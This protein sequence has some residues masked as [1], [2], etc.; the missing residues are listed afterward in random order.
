[1]LNMVGNL[2]GVV[3]IPI[4]AWL[5]GRGEWTGAFALGTALIFIGAALWLLIDAERN[6][7]ESATPANEALGEL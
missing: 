5:T 1:V 2:G 3:G 4:V 6:L 7:G